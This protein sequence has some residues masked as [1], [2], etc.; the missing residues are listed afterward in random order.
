[1]SFARVVV[2]A[3]L[4]S[5]DMNLGAVARGWS[6]M[7]HGPSRTLPPADCPPKGARIA[8]LEVARHELGSVRRAPAG[9]ARR[10][11]R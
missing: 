10:Q 8:G 3:G 4:P 9:R 6:W 2:T 11:S 5:L 7:R 1:M